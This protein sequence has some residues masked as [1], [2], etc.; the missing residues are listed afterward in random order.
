MRAANSSDELVFPVGQAFC[1][2]GAQQCDVLEFASL[3][4]ADAD[5]KHGR[6]PG[7]VVVPENSFD[8]GKSRF[9]QEGPIGG[10]LQVDSANL[11]VE[12]VFLWSDD[13]VGADG[14]KLTIDLVADVGG[15]SDH[16]RGNGD[17]Q[18][19]GGP[20]QRF[21]ALL[22]AERF[23]YDAD[24]HGLRLPEHADSGSDVGLLDGD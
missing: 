14:A 18:S 2:I 17:P 4:N 10:R 5:R 7:D 13:Q 11:Y 22:P 19:D 23:V 8:V 21:A 24:E 3:C 6:K 20:G 1:K 16:R 9:T 12:G 15:D